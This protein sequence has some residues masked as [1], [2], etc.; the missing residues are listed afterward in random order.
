MV[1]WEEV[2]SLQERD[3]DVEDLITQQRA[4]EMLNV[5]L[6]SVRLAMNRGRLPTYFPGEGTG[7]RRTSR[8]AVEELAAERASRL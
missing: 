3:V 1:V 8:L 4:A 7:R 2:K 5:T 6:E